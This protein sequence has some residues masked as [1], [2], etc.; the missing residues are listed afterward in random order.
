[1]LHDYRNAIG[2]RGGNGDK[3]VE[4]GRPAAKKFFLEPLSGLGAH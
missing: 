1:M 2:K 4:A 3:G